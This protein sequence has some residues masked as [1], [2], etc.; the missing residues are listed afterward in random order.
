[1]V[2]ATLILLAATAVA[3]QPPGQI[4]FI[5][6]RDGQFNKLWVMNANGSQATQLTF[7]DGYESDPS[8]SPDGERI[9]F[10]TNPVPGSDATWIATLRRHGGTPVLLTASPGRF[11]S[12]VFSPDG[13][14]V[15]FSRE[16]DPGEWELHAVD[17]AGGEPVHLPMPLSVDAGDVASF[18]QPTWAPDGRTIAFRVWRHSEFGTPTLGRIYRA[19]TD[20]QD[21]QPVTDSNGSDE[22]PAWS[23]D[24]QRLLFSGERPE[25]LG[26]FLVDAAGGRATALPSMRGIARAAGWSPDGEWITFQSNAAGNQ[27]IYLMRLDGSERVNLTEAVTAADTSPAWSPARVPYRP[28]AVPAATWGRIKQPNHESEDR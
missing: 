25:G 2:L 18:D 20:G 28:T 5:S 3:A 13:S 27:D 22:S 7:D 16:I 10:V 17:A 26:L 19:A 12:P 14:R 24:G 15:L 8:W 23:P 6:S 9:V 11:A 1:M 21:L 4:A